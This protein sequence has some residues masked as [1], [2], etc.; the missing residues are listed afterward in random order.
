MAEGQGQAESHDPLGSLE[1]P[2]AD[3]K[4]PVVNQKKKKASWFRTVLWML[5]MM[6]LANV[7]FV[8]LFFVLYHFKIIH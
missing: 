6:L 5:A 4:A 1:N 8:I 7:F 2:V 3:Q